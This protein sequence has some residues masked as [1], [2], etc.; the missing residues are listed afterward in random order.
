[1]GIIITIV[2]ATSVGGST[3]MKTVIRRDREPKGVVEMQLMSSTSVDVCGPWDGEGVV[4]I[5]GASPT[6][7]LFD[8]EPRIN[9]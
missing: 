7:G 9:S 1:L 3:A 4:R 6:I 8:M 5:M 2:E